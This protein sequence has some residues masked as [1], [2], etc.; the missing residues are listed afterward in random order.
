M[1][2]HWRIQVS[3]ICF[4]L[5]LAVIVLWVRSYSWND[6]IFWNHNGRSYLTVESGLGGVDFIGETFTAALPAPNIDSQMT[7]QA[8]SKK[9]KDNLDSIRKDQR[10]ISFFGF[11]A[12][13][14]LGPAN[15]ILIVVPYW[16]IL[17]FLALLCGLPW[18]RRRLNFSLRTFL[19]AFTVLAVLLGFIGWL[20]R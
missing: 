14:V 17:I 1:F 18:Y 10:Y 15:L 20:T 3:F 9:T 11:G 2:R 7:S 12:M 16:F 13:R 8:I 4:T 6:N 19:I 5:L